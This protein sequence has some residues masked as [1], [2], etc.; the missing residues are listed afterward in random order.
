MLS[1]WLYT[2]IKISK[3]DW[4]KNKSN[5]NKIETLRNKDEWIRVNVIQVGNNYFEILV[6]LRYLGSKF[7]ENGITWHQIN[8]MLNERN[9]F[10]NY[11]FL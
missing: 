3:T 2:V 6:R 5:K 10:F 9:R 1:K 8:K 4:I 7:S 11:F